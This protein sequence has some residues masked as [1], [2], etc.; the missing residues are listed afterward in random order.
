MTS[1]KLTET[2]LNEK[3]GHEIAFQA[4]VGEAQ[5]IDAHD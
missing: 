1:C 2:G 4:I 3:G 5:P